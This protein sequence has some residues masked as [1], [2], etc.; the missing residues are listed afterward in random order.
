MVVDKLEHDAVW[1]IVIQDA[2]RWKEQVDSVWQEIEDPAKLMRA[3]V[4]KT[5]YNHIIDLPNKYRQNLLSLEQS[6]KKENE[7]EKDYED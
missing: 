6:L 3:R 7:I 4:I 1:Q 2:T 5:A